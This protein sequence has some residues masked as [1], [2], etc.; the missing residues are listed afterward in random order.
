MDRSRKPTTLSL[1]SLPPSETFF[2]TSIVLDD[3]SVVV[4]SQPR[5]AE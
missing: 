3:V 1:K 5:S 2:A 4:V